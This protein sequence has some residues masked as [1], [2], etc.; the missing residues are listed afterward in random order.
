MIQRKSIPQTSLVLILTHTHARTH[1]I[2]KVYRGPRP[3]HIE[4]RQI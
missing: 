4:S 2:V 3:C 1:A